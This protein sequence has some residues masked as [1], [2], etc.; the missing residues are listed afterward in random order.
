MVRLTQTKN[1]EMIKPS[2]SMVHNNGEIVMKQQ[3]E[4]RY[5]FCLFVGLS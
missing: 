1:G 3:P 4:F 5:L 2:L